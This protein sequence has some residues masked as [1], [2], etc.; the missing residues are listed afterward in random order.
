MK[1]CIMVAYEEEKL[2]ALRKYAEQKG[3]SIEKE[4]AQE[5]ENMYQKYVPGNVKSFIEM[6]STVN[7]PK[8]YKKDPASSAVGSVH[9]EG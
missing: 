4:L 6:K 5:A 2:F 9:S 7:R 8:K 1:K 3:V